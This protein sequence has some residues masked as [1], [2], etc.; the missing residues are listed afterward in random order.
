MPI[1][2]AR[3]P[4]ATWDAARLCT[5]SSAKKISAQNYCFEDCIHGFFAVVYLCRSVLWQQPN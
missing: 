3:V 4:Q 5:Y 1:F 2:D